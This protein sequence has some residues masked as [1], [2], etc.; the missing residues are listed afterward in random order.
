MN[1]TDDMIEKAAEAIIIRRRKMW[2]TIKNATGNPPGYSS[3]FTDRNLRADIAIDLA[4]AALE[5][6]LIEKET[7]DNN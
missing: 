1:I 2:D 3:N 7:S 6:A 4:K 5:A